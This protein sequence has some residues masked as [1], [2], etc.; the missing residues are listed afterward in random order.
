[1]TFCGAGSGAFF[2]KCGAGMW[3]RLIFCGIGTTVKK[4]AG[5]GS[6][7]GSD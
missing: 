3:K 4:E 2:I 6:K 5:S 1:L 7:L